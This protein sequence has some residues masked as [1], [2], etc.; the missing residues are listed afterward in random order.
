[1]SP[2]LILISIVLGIINSGNPFFLQD[3]PGLGCRIFTIVKFKTMND[4]KDNFGNFLDDSQRL[5]KI[6]QIIR[7]LSLDE[8]PQLINVVKGDM[9]L[10][11]LRLYYQNIY[12]YITKIKLGDM[13]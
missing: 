1:M 13:R 6:G 3:R 2:F 8:L 7:K 11:D 12:L 4:K 9:S 5:T 10:I